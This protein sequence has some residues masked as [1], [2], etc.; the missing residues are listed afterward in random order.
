MVFNE[1][2]KI[3]VMPKTTLK[4]T[5]SKT[6]SKPS[7]SKSNGKQEGKPSAKEFSRQFPTDADSSLQELFVSGLRETYWCENHLVKSIPKMVKAAGS[8]KLRQ[9]LEKH[10]EVTKNHAAR[11]EKAFEMLHEK[12][13]AKKCDACEGL[14]MSSEHVIENTK[15]GSPT[16]DTAIIMSALKV[17]NFEITTYKGLI[18]L[19]SSLG[20]K[21][22]LKLLQQ[23][24]DEE[25]EASDLLTELSYMEEPA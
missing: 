20:T 11:L 10:V 1:V 2:N 25:A 21:D 4:R 15:Q 7:N 6:S 14:T 5:V 12:I 19:A 22:V 17:E 9:A 3:F 18:Q 16:R 24:L 23:N 13:V 8:N